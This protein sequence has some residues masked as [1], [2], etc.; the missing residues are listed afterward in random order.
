MNIERGVYLGRS[1][2]GD[3][4]AHSQRSVLVLGPSRSGKTTSLIVPNLLLTNSSVIATS[5]KD[6]VVRSMSESRRDRTTLLFDPSG[7]IHTPPGVIRVGYSPLRASREWDGAVLATRSLVESARRGM[8]DRA[9]DHWTERASA[10]VAPLL[11]A[12]A[13]RR[14]SMGALASRVDQRQG[15]DALELLRERYGS[16]HPS[17]SLLGGVLAT[18]ER[19]RSSIWST[20][21]G[22]FA[23][24]RTEAARRA[25]RESPLNV[26]EFLAGKH[27]LH[28]VSP[29][30]YQSVSAPLIV[31]LIDEIVE[32]TYQRFEQGARTLLA[33]DEM[34]NVAP[35]PRLT[36]IVSEGGGQGVVTLACLQDLSQA[37]SRWGVAAEGF[38]SL[39]PTSVVLPGIA[40]PSTLE[41]IRNLAGKQMVS[42]PTVQRDARGKIQSHS[43]SWVERDRMTLAQVAQG[44]NDHALALDS[45]KNLHWIELTPYYRDSRFAPQRS[46][47]LP[48]ERG[49]SRGRE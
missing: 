18:E 30:R 44:R 19:E 21:S 12:A 1:A 46:R 17:S 14:D 27:H 31:G 28:V 35:L 42:S 16:Q 33:L 47:D 40:D 15:N 48:A 39:F 6:D 24:L 25:S 5:T 23:G 29:S 38:L 9:D 7:T 37:R 41:S 8:G 3:A 49:R 26:E 22:L 34:A 45:S 32:A 36:S 4:F 13:L 2:H 43:S 10:L 11:H 20:A